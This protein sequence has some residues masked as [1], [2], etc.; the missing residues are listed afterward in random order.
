TEDPPIG[1]RLRP[2]RIDDEPRRHHLARALRVAGAGGQRHRDDADEGAHARPSRA[3]RRPGSHAG[4][5]LGAGREAC[6]DRNMRRALP[7]LVALVLAAA[8]ALSAPDPVSSSRADLISAILAYRSALDRLWEFHVV[9]VKRA[10]AEVEKRR[11]LLARG[12][13]S[14]R[15]LEESE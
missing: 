4:A 2:E 9:A 3:H 13:V 8:P 6:Q 5:N 7:S 1:Q 12:I 11:E 10:S 14:R 15:E